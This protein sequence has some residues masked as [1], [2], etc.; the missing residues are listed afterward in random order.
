MERDNALLRAEEVAISFTEGN[1]FIQRADLFERMWVLVSDSNPAWNACC[2]IFS[3]L[4][5]KSTALHRQLAACKNCATVFFPLFPDEYHM[6]QSSAQFKSCVDSRSM[7]KVS[8]SIAQRAL[9]SLAQE[10]NA[11]KK[12]GGEEY[13]KLIRVARGTRDNKGGV[14]YGRFELCE[15]SHVESCESTS[16]VTLM[17]RNL[18]VGVLKLIIQLHFKVPISSKLLRPELHGAGFADYFQRYRHFVPEFADDTLF[19]CFLVEFGQHARRADKFDHGFKLN[20][21][22]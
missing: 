9:V 8:E 7:D 19:R 14:K 21:N 13:I 22:W 6:H 4:K 11:Y 2:S 12:E 16:Q 10:A 15:N 3:A 1:P 18:A 5:K 20:S 17:S